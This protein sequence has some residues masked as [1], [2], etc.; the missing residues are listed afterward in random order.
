MTEEAK[1]I[2]PSV[3]LRVMRENFHFK[4]VFGASKKG[5]SVNLD[6]CPLG[7]HTVAKTS[8]GADVLA[9]LAKLDEWEQDIKETRQGLLE[10]IE[11][12]LRG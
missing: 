9:M 11:N 2:D 1:A 10:M 4:R 3:L 7:I 12:Q 6:R 5:Y 8:S